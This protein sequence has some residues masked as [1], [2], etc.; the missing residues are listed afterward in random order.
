MP[1]SMPPTTSARV[2]SPTLFLAGDALVV[3]P[4]SRVDDPGFLRLVATMR[5]ADAT[6]VNLETVIHE[7]ASPAQ[8]DAGGTHMASPPAVARELAWAGVDLVSAANNHA[9]DYGPGGV[10]ETIAHARGAGLAIAGIGEDLQRARAATAVDA[11]GTRVALVS[12]TATFAPHHRASASRL[13]L[14]GRPGVNPLAVTHR[15]VVTIPAAMMAR[16]GGFRHLREGR[17]VPGEKRLRLAGGMVEIRGGPWRE[18][19]VGAR[20]VAASRRANLAAIEAAAGQA[21]ITVVAI[22]SHA[23]GPWLR[24]FAREAIGAGAA[25]V[26]VHGPHTVRGIE[27]RDRAIVLYGTGDFVYQPHLVSRFPSDAYEQAGLTEDADPGEL[28]ALQQ[29]HMGL[30]KRATYEGAAAIVGFRDAR[31]SS[32]RLLPVDLRF[33]APPSLRGL[34]RLA[35]PALGREIIGTIARRSRR[36]R[37]RVRYDAE[38]NEGVVDLA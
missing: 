14:P 27:V 20:I 9:L 21:D 34:P 28:V 6:I 2:G 18:L 4:W 16:I 13:D 26:H 23:Q 1:R 5:A 24:R 17:P 3:A 25:I 12:M 36:Y 33:D 32:L 15:R 19:G 11:A 10:L 8:A 30:H 38:R 37:T 35:D 22:H 29:R 31:P 7:Y